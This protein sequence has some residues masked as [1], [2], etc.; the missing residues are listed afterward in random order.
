MNVSGIT[1]VFRRRWFVP[2]V[3]VFALI[4]RLGRLFSALEYDEIWTLENFAGQNLKFIFTQ[5]ALPNN[6]PLYTLFIKI[7]GFDPEYYWSIRL[8]SLAAGM[9]AIYLL[10]KIAEEL[11][12]DNDAGYFMLLFAAFSAPF[13]AYSTL[14]RGYELQLFLLAGFGLSLLK[15]RRSWLSGLPQKNFL[16][17]LCAAATGILAE[18]TLPTSVIYLFLTTLAFCL[19]SL[20]ERKKLSPEGKKRQLAA[21]VSF[22][23]LAIFTLFWYLSNFKVFAEATKWGTEISGI[24]QFWDFLFRSSGELAIPTSLVAAAMLYTVKDRRG[25]LISGLILLFWLSAV[26]THA[27]PS[28]SYIPAAGYSLLLCAFAA[29]KLSAELEQKSPRLRDAAAIAV[30]AV[31]ALLNAFCLKKNY[32]QTDY[33]QLADT[34][35]GMPVNILPLAGAAEGYPARWHGGRELVQDY[36]IRLE[37]MPERLLLLSETPGIE[38]IEAGSGKTASLKIEQ[39]GELF[40]NGNT[41]GMIF[42]LYPLNRNAEAGEIIFMLFQDT[43]HR[44]MGNIFSSLK[45]AGMPVILLN[46]WLTLPH[47][48]G[49]VKHYSALTA[50]TASGK[51]DIPGGIAGELPGGGKIRFFTLKK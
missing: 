18:L 7:T 44:E 36:R 3:F 35:S 1:A 26:F 42:Q 23:I 17:E 27:G 37:G 47:S 2:A 4:L 49:G 38:G 39:S 22:S 16:P 19:I 21:G 46:P 8:L 13:N 51:T 34:V 32:V 31:F 41:G 45:K 24:W 6:H 30:L 11:F 28:R 29:G 5:L 48:K 20:Y 14:A 25:K 9:G 50:F 10:W 40:R 43:P 12:P 33:F 15:M